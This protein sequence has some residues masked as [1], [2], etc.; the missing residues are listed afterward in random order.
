MFLLLVQNKIEDAF[1]K[2]LKIVVAGTPTFKIHAAQNKNA[3]VSPGTFV[4]WDEGY[5]S[6][7]PD[8]DFLVA[9]LIIT[10]VISIIDKKTLCL[11]LG[12]K[13]IAAEN[14]LPR[15]KF[16]NAGDVKPVAQNEEHLI[17]EVADTSLHKVGNVWYGVPIHICPTV[18]LYNEVMV[19]Q[20]EKVVTK[21]KVIARDRMIS[22]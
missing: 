18:A 11:D 14:P 22:V 10:R 13:A 12:H 9:A 1:T 6:T 16:L 4:F 20:D 15:I 8:L 17:V 19:V 2:K 5:G 21:W 7:M 3:E